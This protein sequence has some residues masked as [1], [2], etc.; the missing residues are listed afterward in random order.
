MRESITV[1][2]ARPDEEEWRLAERSTSTVMVP[3]IL[4]SYCKLSPARGI[5]RVPFRE[6]VHRV[7]ATESAL[8]SFH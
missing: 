2:S 8:S 5:V 6:T 4:G 7:R 1:I 3:G